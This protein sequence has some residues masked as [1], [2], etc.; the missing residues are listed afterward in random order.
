MPA[1][2][3][4]NDLVGAYAQPPNWGNTTRGEQMLA[5]GPRWKNEANLNI[6]ER[7]QQLAER[8]R[9]RAPDFA[10]E[11]LNAIQKAQ[12]EADVRRSKAPLNHQTHINRYAY[13]T[14]DIAAS[15]QPWFDKLA[16]PEQNEIARHMHM[17]YD[18]A[19]DPIFER[20]KDF[21]QSSLPGIDAQHAINGSFYGG[22]RLQQQT[23]L[24]RH[25][26]NRARTEALE[27]QGK[28]YP[29]LLH[30]LRGTNAQHTATAQATANVKE[31]EA[32]A[33]R[34]QALALQGLQGDELKN[35]HLK[36]VLGQQAGWREQEQAQRE[37]NARLQEHEANEQYPWVQV[38]RQSNVM[39]NMQGLPTI[40]TSN[41]IQ[42]A[43]PAPNG[44]QA[45]A[46]VTGLTPNKL[47]QGAKKR[48]GSVKGYADGGQVNGS[49]P[50]IMDKY[51][52]AMHNAEVGQM[53]QSA[54]ALQKTHPNDQAQS[55]GLVGASILQGMGG[56][57]GAFGAGQE[58]AIRNAQGIESARHKNIARSSSIL[59]K[60]QSSRLDQQKMLMQHQ[61]NLRVEEE[62]KRIHDAQIA[63]YGALN[64]KL[65]AES[66]LLKGEDLPLSERPTLKMTPSRETAITSATNNIYKLAGIYESAQH[67]EEALSKV[68]TGTPQAAISEFP[69]WGVAPHVS[70]ALGAGKPSDIQDAIARSNDLLLALRDVEGAGGRSVSELM[71][72]KSGKIGV[73]QSKKFNA[74]RPHEIKERLLLDMQKEW[75]RAKRSGASPA[76]LAE[77]QAFIES[78]QNPMKKEETVDHEE[79][80]EAKSSPEKQKI[81]LL[82]EAIAAKKMEN[83]AKK[84]ELGHE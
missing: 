1:D 66:R 44:W 64:T 78:L 82:K 42:P 27:A 68:H 61:K 11:P 60:I 54:Q 57:M 36:S 17:F 3:N 30:H 15:A 13:H 37:R 56:P 53:Q 2:T 47:Q 38:A 33:H 48:G 10:V 55:L 20:A 41:V 67:A 18:S 4:M 83:D 8:G 70:G 34:N 73:G 14:P 75:K 16:T 7:L 50:P 26:G 72:R 28:F 63:H 22:H 81:A 71:T 84:R 31:Q 49:L 5:S 12:N 62:T 39:N 74:E 52:P 58:K 6:A 43:P 29:E 69:S 9:I 19:I 32:N 21:Y 76:D 24:L 23:D 35:E 79:T 45:A 40:S 25:L 65:E 80:L 46:G 51:L 59:E 77:L